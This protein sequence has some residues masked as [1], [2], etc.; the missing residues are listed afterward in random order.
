MSFGPK[1]FAWPKFAADILAS[2]ERLCLRF[3]NSRRYT[4][5]H[6]GNPNCS[7]GKA[8]KR[9]NRCRLAA[10]LC[11]SIITSATAT[12]VAVLAPGLV[13]WKG[14]IDRKGALQLTELLKQHVP[15]QTIR[16]TQSDGGVR[17]VVIAISKT[18]KQNGY[19]T[20]ALGTCASGCAMAF[21]AGHTRSL[22]PAPPGEEPTVLAYHGYYDP[23]TFQP[24]DPQEDDIKYMVSS[25]NGGIDRGLAIKILSTKSMNGGLL[26]LEPQAMKTLHQSEISYCDKYE[27]SV[28]LT[29]DSV[30]KTAESLG[31]VSHEQTK[32]QDPAPVG[33]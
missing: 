30:A 3:S 32:F 25:T 1:P 10:A 14:N 27:G 20:E 24:L 4:A 11:L 15:I 16:F 23:K 22:L 18:I 9:R 12:E 6:Q 31:I 19:A 2:I 26:V 5:K 17:G 29:C 28:K 21:L 7:T 33:R 8:K 13:Q